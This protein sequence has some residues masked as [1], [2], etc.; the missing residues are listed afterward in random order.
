MAATD[1]V[2]WRGSAAP[3]RADGERVPRRRPRVSRSPTSG[4]GGPR[5]LA[6]APVPLKAAA[7]ASPRPPGLLPALGRGR[8]VGG[9]RRG[10]APPRRRRLSVF[11]G[12][13]SRAIHTRYCECGFRGSR[14]HGQHRAPALARLGGIRR[15]RAQPP[16][17]VRR[18]GSLC[19]HPAPDTGRCQS[20]ALGVCVLAPAHH[21]ADAGRPPRVAPAPRGARPAWHPP[22]VAPAGAQAGRNASSA[23]GV[24]VVGTRGLQ[25]PGAAAAILVAKVR[26]SLY[27]WGASGGRCSARGGCT[28]ACEPHGRALGQ[29]PA[30]RSVFACVVSAAAPW[31]RGSMAVV[32]LNGAR[33]EH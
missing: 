26:S 12:G 33:S 29:R 13:H 28:T 16:R 10:A 20:R 31:G 19:H 24:G 15:W 9:Q 18:E 2:W 23:A 3:V 6:A 1:A 14:S 22:R 17:A 7:V 27:G 32:L 8:A 21:R 4:R 5:A 11:E 30:L 25:Y